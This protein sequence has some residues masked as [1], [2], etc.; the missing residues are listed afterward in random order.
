MAKHILNIDT[1]IL[2]VLNL[3]NLNND[4]GRLLTINNSNIVSERTISEIAVEG[5]FELKSNKGIANG[6]VPLDNSGLIPQAYLPPVTISETFVVASQTA[7]LAL[8]AQT[9]DV[10]VRTDEN[11]SYILQGTDPSL[12]TDWQELLSPTDV[13]QSVNG[14]TGTISL[15]LIFNS[16]LLSITGGNSV[17]LDS[18]YYTETEVNNLLT[19]YSQIGH[20]HTISDIT[21]FP[22][23]ISHFNND[24][25]YLTSFTETDPI[26]TAHTASNIVNGTGL[27]KNDGVGNWS[28]DN[29]TYL[30]TEVNDLTQAVVWDNVPDANITQSSVVQHQTALTI[31]ESQISDLNHF[32]PSTLLT[33]YGF[34]DNS[35]NWNTAYSW[36][37]HS[38][39]Y[40]LL[41]HTHTFNSLT[42]KPTTLSGY[43][44]T[45]VY[46]KTESE[47][48]Y[49]NVTGDTM[50]GDLTAPNF[51]GNGSGL[52]G[53]V[54]FLTPYDLSNPP[55]NSVSFSNTNSPTGIS[56]HS[57]V[58][59][60]TNNSYITQLLGRNDKL[61]FRT[62]ENGVFT[63]LRELY[64]TGNF[65]PTDYLNKNT[66]G[67]ITG[68]TLYDKTIAEQESANIKTV[69]NREFVED[70]VANNASGSTNL[71]YTSG[72]T[73]GT[74]TSD[75]GTNAVIPTV[76][77]SFA[78]LQKPDFYKEGTFTPVL[79]DQGGG[80][81]YTVGTTTANFT[82]TG[83][84]VN[85]TVIFENISTTGTPTGTLTINELPEDQVFGGTSHFTIK[86]LKGSDVSSSNLD[87]AVMEWFGLKQIAL[88]NYT[89]ALSI[90][91]VTFTG[92]DFRV[93]GTYKTNVY[94]P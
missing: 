61:H 84:I 74:V 53:V 68:T 91:G 39:L 67:T 49:V 66:G 60:S 47:S 48:R 7:M 83:N 43:G 13:V 33:D 86:T 23:D 50:T 58:F 70:Y 94:T 12:L 26:F 21:D 11:K 35:T 34:T 16:G 9:G 24:S 57:L 85:F 46:T 65:T 75:T 59:G 18:R 19:G 17:N 82:R 73:N 10:A 22:T 5:N 32:T 92:G 79:V 76:T 56:Q 52:T 38:G 41:G 1:D 2:G 14:L 62:R 29:S 64:H 42:S 69:V 28:Y 89:D 55:A 80:A 71:S 54:R 44:I 15:D 77:S 90:T 88:Y 93:S 37:N 51:I 72:V 78:G 63:P 31:T 40:S 30:T 81:T 4:T 45:D 20:T 25:G 8:V 36:G 87:R 3:P 27:L 6:Y